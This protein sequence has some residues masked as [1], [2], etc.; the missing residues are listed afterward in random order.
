MHVNGACHCGQIKYEAEIDPATV[1]IC[2]CTDCQTI[3]GSA[4][5]VNV[6]AT[7]ENFRML[8]GEPKTYVKVAASGAR[9]LQVFCANCGTA[10]AGRF[11]STVEH[12][13]RRRIPVR[14]G[15]SADGGA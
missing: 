1:A 2:H 15:G 5:R 8:C 10:V 7:K 13:G 12:F 4:F 9:R 11:E 3:T 6:I 14:I